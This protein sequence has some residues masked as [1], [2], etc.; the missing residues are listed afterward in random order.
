M[1]RYLKGLKGKA[2]S[3]TL[4]QTEALRARYSA[5]AEATDSAAAELLLADSKAAGDKPAKIVAR[6]DKVLKVLR[7]ICA[8]QASKLRLQDKEE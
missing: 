6:A 2:A 1:C 8:A 3:T 7:K 5:A 4:E